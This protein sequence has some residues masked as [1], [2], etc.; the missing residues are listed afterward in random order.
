MSAIR[1]ALRWLPALA[2][3]LMAGCSTV[4][5]SPP[6][7]IAA[8][9]GKLIVVATGL[10]LLVIVPVIAMTLL[11]AWRYRASNRK[12]TYTPDWDHSTQLELV[13]WAI[14]LLIIIALGAITW[15]STHLLD[16]HRPLDRIAPGR[17][18]PEGVEPLE[19]QVVA[20][21][22]KWLFV[23]PE[24]GVASVNEM[25][26]PVDRPIRFRLTSSSTM[27]AFYVPA[28]AG[29][30]YTMPAMETKLHAVMNEAGDYE[31]LSSHYSGE[32]FSHMRFRFHALP[33]EGF[34]QWIAATRAGG[35]A[36]TRDEYLK[37]EVPSAREPA[38]RYASVDSGLFDAVVNR[39]VDT[40]RLCMHQMMAYDAMG[41]LGLDAIDALARPRR[42]NL[43]SGPFVSAGVCTVDRLP[44]P[45]PAA[46][47][48]V[49]GGLQA[50]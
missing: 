6:G 38:R 39:C 20:L 11:F 28:L 47:Q 8:Q 37:L 32:G 21:D 25:A 26:A 49:A 24:Y 18:V 44:A 36:L 14:P 9:Q 31:G 40:D 19:V 2:L 22:W 15:I 48:S 5:L 23:Y 29:M 4:V 3:P 16:P 1:R 7:D 13:I 46:P 12:A 10:M 33:E 35:G 41:G 50:P 43:A 42:G 45:F 30:I 34:S 17:P 27:N